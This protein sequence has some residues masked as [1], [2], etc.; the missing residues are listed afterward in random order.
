MRIFLLAF[1]LTLMV[2]FASHAQQTKVSFKSLRAPVDYAYVT[3]I[4]STGNETKEDFL[5]RAGGIMEAY[6]QKTG[7][8]VCSAIYE[9]QG[10]VGLYITTNLA[11]IG[12]I[13]VNNPPMPNMV[14]TNEGIHTHPTDENLRLNQ[15][16]EVLTN[17]RKRNRAPFRPKPLEFSRTDY[18]SGAGYL[19]AMGVM[20]Y[21]N[22]VGSVVEKGQVT[23]PDPS[24]V[25]SILPTP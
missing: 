13:T 3:S 11:H 7:F 20:M 19:V 6:T 14:L 4:V 8:E 21:Q 2:P 12:C 17:F 25:A 16:D 22:G 24:V 5:R 9:S 10:R 15:N 1:F 23:P 18:E